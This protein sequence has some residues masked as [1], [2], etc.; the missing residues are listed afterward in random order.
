MAAKSTV[1]KNYRKGSVVKKPL[2]LRLLHLLLSACSSGSKKHMHL[3]LNI[4]F[5]ALGHIRTGAASVIQ[6][7]YVITPE[8]EVQFL[9]TSH[10]QVRVDRDSGQR[11]LHVVVH[12]DKNRDPS[13]PFREVYL[14]EHVPALEIYPLAEVLDYIRI[15]RPNSSNRFL[16]AAPMGAQGWRTYRPD[17]FGTLKGHQPNANIKKLLVTLDHGLT[18][19]EMRLVGTTS[20]R[21][22]LSQTL[23]EDGWP[24]TVRRDMGAWSMASE[25]MD[26]YTT[27][28]VRTRLTA[29][30]RL[31]ER[32]GP[33]YYAPD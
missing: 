10:L 13:M 26:S 12:A 33:T 28:S 32:L 11:Y 24:R 8:Q 14:P 30:A 18:L 15:H 16:L 20:L 4:M 22:S 3:R 9:P 6:A 31:G 27:T 19:E 17:K 1:T 21:K 23:E 5:I 7:H 29:L 2:T 25:S